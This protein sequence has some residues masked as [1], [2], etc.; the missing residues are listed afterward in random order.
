MPKSTWDQD[1]AEALSERLGQVVSRRQQ[2]RDAR[3][4]RDA[5]ERNRLEIAELQRRHARALIARH[6]TVTA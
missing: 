1:T 3:A 4:D 2:L 6:L 5:L